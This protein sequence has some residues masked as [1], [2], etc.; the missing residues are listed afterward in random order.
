MLYFLMLHDPDA[1]ACL[2]REVP[3]HEAA[4]AAYDALSEPER[5]RASI[6][7][8]DSMTTLERLHDSSARMRRTLPSAAAEF[9]ATS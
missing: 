4:L 3:T 7:A 2:A 5:S 9:Q 6:A 1:R 8:A